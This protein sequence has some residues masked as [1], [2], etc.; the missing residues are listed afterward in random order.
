MHRSKM[1]ERERALHSRLAQLVSSCE[2]IRGT[3][4]NRKITCG[5]S[6]CRCTKADKHEVVCLVR[7]KKGHIEQLHVPKDWEKRVRQ[8]V[9][10]Y[11]LIHEGLERLSCIYWEKIRNRQE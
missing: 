4:T 1:S 11:R 7:S 5:K 6:N 9:R 3:L 2:I 10:Q 8:W